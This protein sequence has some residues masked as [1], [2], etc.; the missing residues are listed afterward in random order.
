MPSPGVRGICLPRPG[1]TPPRTVDGPDA[2]LLTMHTPSGQ[3]GASM[4]T[5]RLDQAARAEGAQERA[6]L[7][8]PGSD[9]GGIELP[10]SLEPKAQRSP[11]A[12][13]APPEWNRDEE[14]EPP[15]RSSG[16]R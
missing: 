8:T 15:G 11:W 6:D 4:P 1:S 2:G 12:W 13:A 5:E 3:A 10:T 7:E 9:P 16:G 14:D